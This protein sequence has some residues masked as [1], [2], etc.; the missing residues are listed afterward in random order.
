MR[1][2][3]KNWIKTY[4]FAVYKV[5]VFS[6]CPDLTEAIKRVKRHIGYFCVSIIKCHA[7]SQPKEQ[8][9]Y[10]RL[11]IERDGVYPGGEGMA[12][13]GDGVVGAGNWPIT[14][15][16]ANMKQRETR[17]WD[18]PIYSPYLPQ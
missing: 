1:I 18:V 12:P 9:I 6:F 11:R 2:H 3:I 13:V 14:F 4:I 16:S 17:K 8:R 5:V 10:F 7:Q 15:P